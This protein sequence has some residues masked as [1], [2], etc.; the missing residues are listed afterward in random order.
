MKKICV[1]GAGYV[2]LVTATCLADLGN[3]V[4]CVD[5]D[6]DRIDGLE[7]GIMPIFEPGL[8][9]LVQQNQKQERISFSTSM[10]EGVIDSEVIIIAV[11]T[12]PKEGGG[13][14][15]KYVEAVAAEI[16]RY[17]NGYKVIV[18]KSTVP[19]GTGARV[20]DL[21]RSRQE[22]EFDF[23]IVSNP[24]FLREGSAI[25]D[26]KRPDRIVLGCS[27]ARALH[28]MRT[29]YDP[30][31]IPPLETP[32][33]STNVESAEM[34]K[35]ASNAFLA[36]KI[37]FIN[38]IANVCE[39][40]G[41]D[42]DTVAK[43]MGMDSRIGPKFLH[44]GI[45]YG[46]SCFPKDTEGLLEIAANAGYD[47]QIVDAVMKVNDAQPLRVIQKLHRVLGDLK[48]RT[49]GLLGLSFKPNTDDLRAAPSERIIA[50]LRAL[51]ARVRAHDPVAGEEALRHGWD[52]EL[53]RSVYETVEGCDAMVVVTEWDAFKELDLDRVRES[54]RNPVVID[55]RNIYDPANVIEAGFHYDGFGRGSVAS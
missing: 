37:S 35:Y 42:I 46:G 55:G 30:L 50:E 1:V 44:A 31:S 20:Q 28:I 21:I 27:S 40:V 24:E 33:I 9:E 10:R 15:L 38:E 45:G 5:I 39:R 36:T 19:A 18:N 22:Q 34:I 11:G 26:F 29:I 16:A 3:E 48:G 51:G 53:C 2:G 52:V 14:D 4:I 12:P 32:I 47:L 7:N 43:G 54:M 6:E 41:A 13:V 49:I 23:D 8:A 17:M 25:N